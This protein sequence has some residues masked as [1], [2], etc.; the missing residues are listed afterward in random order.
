MTIITGNEN[1]IRIFK[2]PD[3]FPSGFCFGGGRAVNFQMMDWFNPIPLEYF[4]DYPTKTL[5]AEEMDNLRSDV[6]QMIKEKNY[7]DSKSRYIAL[8]EYGDVFF[9]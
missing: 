4:W 3:K 5:S 2:L 9:I 6:R 1:I 7:Y 8:A